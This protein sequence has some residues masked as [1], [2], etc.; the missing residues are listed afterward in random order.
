M[1]Q[2]Q[3]QKIINKTKLSPR[4]KVILVFWNYCRFDGSKPVFDQEEI[5]KLISPITKDDF[6]E[7]GEWTN[8]IKTAQIWDAET[9]F[10]YSRFL[11]FLNEITPIISKYGDGHETKKKINNVSFYST[12]LNIKVTYPE[13]CSHIFIDL[14]DFMALSTCLMVNNCLLNNAFNL[15]NSSFLKNLRNLS[16]LR[17]YYQKSISKLK[18]FPDSYLKFTIINN[19]LISFFQKNIEKIIDEYIKHLEKE[20]PYIVLL[21]PNQKNKI[22]NETINKLCSY[23]QDLNITLKDR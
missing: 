15:E 5:R 10:R 23:F 22:K 2:N 8:L 14:N 1:N 4:E 7:Y 13:I 3:I 12:T 11:N 20:F 6:T 18:Y 17:E 16:K 9:D 21:Y 19:F